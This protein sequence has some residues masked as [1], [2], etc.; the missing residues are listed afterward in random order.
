[1]VQGPVIFRVTPMC[2]ACRWASFR[3]C[4]LHPSCLRTFASREEEIAILEAN[5]DDLNPQVIGYVMDTA[6]ADGALDVFTTPVQMKKSRPGTV[7][8]ILARPEDEERMRELLFRESSTL[9]RAL[10]TR[11]TFRAGTPPR[12]GHHAVGQ[13]ANQDRRP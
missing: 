13:C 12:D 4:S 9:G 5:L 8:T 2:C 11:K 1:M 10:A 7:L 3:K 6:L